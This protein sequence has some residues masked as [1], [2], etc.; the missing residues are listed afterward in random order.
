MGRRMSIWYAQAQVILV[1]AGAG[2]FGMRR[3]RLFWYAQAQVILVCAGAGHFVMRK[4]RPFW[5]AQAQVILVCASAFQ[6]D[7]RR[8]RSFF[9]CKRRSDY[10]TDAQLIFV[11]YAQVN[12]LVPCY[13][14]LLFKQVTV[15]F[16]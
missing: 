12:C 2:Q 16:I 4:R 1:C 11:F 9:M 5:Y 7:M 14:F 3:R 15:F 6:F 8:R 13:S 10:Y